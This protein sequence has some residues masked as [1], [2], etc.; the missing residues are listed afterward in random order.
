MKL[1]LLS[2]FI[3]QV[4]GSRLEWTH[5]TPRGLRV[6]G[7]RRILLQLARS[8]AAR[9]GKRRD[10]LR[11]EEQG[12]LRVVCSDILT[13][14]SGGYGGYGGGGAPVNPLNPFG[15]SGG[16]RAP[17]SSSRNDPFVDPLDKASS[18]LSRYSSRPE[19]G[20]SSASG[21][22]SRPGTSRGASGGG[23]GSNY[24]RPTSAPQGG[25]GGVDR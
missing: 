5:H 24:I 12:G 11:G 18:L 14:M 19:S 15:L 21:G 13:K 10:T 4:R 25:V 17:S 16:S 8:L 7:G 6:G 9:E 23:S 1:L 3:N 22:A 2:L 20:G